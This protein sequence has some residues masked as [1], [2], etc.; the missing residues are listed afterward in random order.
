MY[1]NLIFKYLN[2]FYIK[3]VFKGDMKFILVLKF[4]MYIFEKSLDG[5]G[6]GFF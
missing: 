2:K 6:I 5:F 4:F 1:I 3:V